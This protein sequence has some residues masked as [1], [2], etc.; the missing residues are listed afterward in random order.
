MNNRILYRPMFRRGGKVDSRGTGITSGL[1]PR[2][3]YA[4]G[5]L[6]TKIN[7][8][9]SQAMGGDMSLAGSTIPSIPNSTQAAEYLNNQKSTLFPNLDA[10]FTDALLGSNFKA[11]SEKNISNLIE[12]QG[13]AQEEAIQN[14]LA[15]RK[16]TN[17]VGNPDM[18]RKTA[19]ATGLTDQIFK[20][21]ETEE[22][23]D[24]DSLPPSDPNNLEDLDDSR[25]RFEKIQETALEFEKMLGS[26]KKEDIF[27]MLTAAA[28]GLLADDYGAAIKAAG[29]V[30]KGSRKIKQDAKLLAIQDQ[31][32]KE[33]LEATTKA[34]YKDPAKV[35]EYNFLRTTRGGGYS[36]EKAG[37]MVWGGG[38]QFN[39][40]YTDQTQIAKYTEAFSKEN[41]S[42]H[43]KDNASGYAQGTLLQNRYAIPSLKYE[44]DVRKTIEDPATGKDIPNPNL[45]KYVV[46]PPTSRIFFDPVSLYI[47]VF[48]GE[49]NKENK[50]MFKSFTWQEASDAIA[51]NAEVNK[52][53]EE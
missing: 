51:L 27:D 18:A 14:I 32:D 8:S 15:T 47:K 53:K 42:E 3:N 19:R 50:P 1:M 33:K 49:R 38:Q 31:L 26:S 36:A 40:E 4:R 30:G 25:T 10:G 46:V 2:K 43:M 48:T 20:Q 45:G 7:P 37:E 35:N 44:Y 5:D 13:L 22:T 6:V 29:E 12:E 23:S 39:K 9:M 34:S 16:A 52:K 11:D 17:E 24:E 28:P 41:M 21:E